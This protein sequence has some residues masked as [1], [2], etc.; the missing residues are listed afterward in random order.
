MTKR[1]HIT[2]RSTEKKKDSSVLLSYRSKKSDGVPVSHTLSFKKLNEG[3]T[4]LFASLVV[5]LVLAIGLAI[6]NISLQ[7]F[8][9]SSSGKESQ[10]AFY[11]ADTAVE[12][13][14]YYDHGKVDGFAF[15]GSQSDPAAPAI[16]CNGQAAPSQTTYSAP[17]T[18]TTYLINPST[19]CD[20][21]KPSY[22][23]QVNKSPIGTET[24]FTD[25]RA[26]GYNTC[27]ATN[28]R[29]VERGLEVKY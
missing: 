29:R 28:Q 15:P 23:I 10:V 24:Y 27:D 11:N 7:Q 6:T 12:C 19:A 13:A 8:L 20:P 14:L 5:S 1:T 9:L 26:R 22:V 17:T 25:I 4:L 2:K 18:T 3:F 21:A 16:V